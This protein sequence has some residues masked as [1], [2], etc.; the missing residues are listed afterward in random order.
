MLVQEALKA[1]STH[2]YV[3]SGATYTS[4][5]FATSLQAALVKEKAGNRDAAGHPTRRACDGHADRHRS[6]RWASDG[7]LLDAAF[8]EFR[9]VDARFSTYRDDSEIMRI[10]RG[11]LAIADAHPDV[12]EIIERCEGLRAGT[13]RLLRHP[14]GLGVRGS[15]RPGS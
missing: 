2:I 4:D 15:T 12:R 3:I 1:Q 14:R 7:D 8:D 6:A 9:A 11:E 10:N 5:A 13:R